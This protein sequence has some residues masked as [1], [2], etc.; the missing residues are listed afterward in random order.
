MKTALKIIIGLLLV[1]ALI[2]MIA[3]S[4][5]QKAIRRTVLNT[6][7]FDIEIGRLHIGLFEPVVEVTAAQLINPEDFPEPT[8]MEIKTLRVVY[9]LK[10]LWSQEVHFREILV[11]VPRAILLIREDGESNLLRLGKRVIESKESKPQDKEPEVSTKTEPKSS[12]RK[13]RVDV[14]TLRLDR[15]EMRRYREETERPEVKEYKIT[16]D[17]TATDVTDLS[18]VNAMITAGL[19]EGIGSE[20]LRSLGRVLGSSEQ[21]SE[22]LEKASDKLSEQLQKLRNATAEGK[23]KRD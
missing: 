9:D 23:A 17:R 4:M 3:N 22:T 10:S 11:D 14:L 20:T 16:L 13:I 6:T 12:E 18:T 1:I 2:A 7:G 19:I 5:V 8:A 21:V 15:V